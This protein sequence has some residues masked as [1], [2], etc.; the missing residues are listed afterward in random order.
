MRRCHDGGVRAGDGEQW[1][2]IVEV[3]T[4]WRVDVLT[5]EE[6]AP[7][8]RGYSETPKAGPV[9]EEESSSAAL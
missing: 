2:P 8:G 3:F 1:R 7:E 5:R 4:F 6:L 9:L